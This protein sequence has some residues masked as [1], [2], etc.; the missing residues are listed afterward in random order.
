VRLRA[1]ILSVLLGSLMPLVGAESPESP[2]PAEPAE[3]AVPA[4][5]PDPEIQQMIAAV[6]PERIERTIFVLSSFKTR[7]ALSDPL[8]SGDGIGGAC[9]WIRAEFER[10]SRESGGRLKVE[11]DSFRQPPEIPR[12]LA[13]VQITNVVATLPGRSTDPGGRVYVISG[14][15]DSRVTNPLDATSP[16]PGADDDASGVAAVIELAH[17]LSHHQFGPTIVFLAVDAEEENLNGSAH[18]A[19]QA[20]ERGLNISAMLN[21]DIIGSSHA[22]D[23]RVDRHTV[24]LFA[25]GV[26]PTAHPDE[27]LLTLLRSGG[28]NDTPPRELARAIRDVAA[29]YV[30]EMKVRLIYRA[31]RTLRGGDELSFLAQGYPAVRFTEPTEDYRHQHQD[32]R[33][34]GGVAYGDLPAFVDFGYVADVARING[35]ALAAL[36]LA[37]A[38]PAQ[39][40]I[41]TA[42][43]ENDTT[44]RWAPN[45]EPNLAGYRL[46]WRE[47]TAP[48]WEHG[49]DLPKGVTRYTLR[50]LSKDNLIFGLEAFDTGGHVSPA[51]FP[52]PRRTL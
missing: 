30:P 46:V 39:V 22:A 36:A 52:S 49:L 23:G 28:E 4:L 7:H 18:W 29:T 50:G 38:T 44:L 13:P 42:Q 6:S 41:E 21:N 12:I 37:P 40:Q 45:A 47:T 25:E 51:A 2:A 34:E 1:P 3:S 11:L 14:H 16:A 35:A 24:R 8:P 27:A 19:R 15:Y 5:K 26:P 17:I 9:S 32:V 48:Y 10:A 43:L 33:E 20:R 31:E